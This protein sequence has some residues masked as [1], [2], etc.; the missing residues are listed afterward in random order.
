MTRY[1][2]FKMIEGCN[3]KE[4]SSWSIFDYRVNALMIEIH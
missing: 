2:A 4:E 3:L 1:G